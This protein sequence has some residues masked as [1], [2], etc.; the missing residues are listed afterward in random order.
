MAADAFRLRWWPLYK[1]ELKRFIIMA[2]KYDYEKMLSD[3]NSEYGY[4][5]IDM[6][7]V[8]RFV[9]KFKCTNI[10]LLYDW[11]VS[12]NIHHGAHE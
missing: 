7:I 2:K 10:H 9:R 12:Q 3:F 1:V 4:V 11:C 8:K 5:T 6:N